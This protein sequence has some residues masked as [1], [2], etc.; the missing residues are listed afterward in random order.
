MSLV[1]HKS[2]FQ[3][4]LNIRYLFWQNFPSRTPARE[5][6]RPTRTLRPP[7]TR[8]APLGTETSTSNYRKLSA[9]FVYRMAEQGDMQTKAIKAQQF[10]ATKR[11]STIVSSFQNIFDVGLLFSM[12]HFH[13]VLKLNAIDSADKLRREMKLEIT[14]CIHDQSRLIFN[15]FSVD[16]NNSVE[17]KRTLK[18]ASPNQGQKI[19]KQSHADH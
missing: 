5:R 7:R 2:Y 19:C 3:K 11:S 16:G 14:R 8:A 18:L 4:I 12:F 15:L 1:I 10:M 17:F 13:I 6:A 9:I